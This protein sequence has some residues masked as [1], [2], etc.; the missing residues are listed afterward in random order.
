M[1]GSGEHEFRAIVDSPLAPLAR[2]L[3]MVGIDCEIAGE[4]IRADA[5]GLQGLL[6]VKVDVALQDAAIRHAAALV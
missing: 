3:R 1:P 5:T 6:R 4:Y 2:K